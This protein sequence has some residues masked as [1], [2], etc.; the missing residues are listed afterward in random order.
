M[1]LES[2]SI[3]CNTFSVFLNT[4]NKI[5]KNIVYAV[6]YIIQSYV[7]TIIGYS[8]VCSGEIERAITM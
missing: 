7:L 2:I 6:C 5:G 4:R 1:Y 3:L 8:H